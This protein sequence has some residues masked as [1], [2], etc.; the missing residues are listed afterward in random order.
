MKKVLDYAQFINEKSSPDKGKVLFVSFGKSEKNSISRVD[1]HKYLNTK[2]DCTFSSW[3]DLVFSENKILIGNKNVSDF[4]FVFMGVVGENGNYF[5]TLEKYCE[6]N[7]IPIFKY[8]C[9]TERNNKVY[10]NTTMSLSG[11]PQIPTIISK[12]SLLK[13][14][15]LV[16]ELNL[17][18]VTKI[19]NGSQGKGVEIQKTKMDLEKYLKKNKDETIIFQKFIENEGDY[20]IFII[21]QDIMYS[22]KRKSKDDKKEF[23][24]NYSL[25]GTAERLEIPVKAMNI[26]KKASK[27]MGF[28]V[29]GVD[30]IKEKGTDN[31]YVL[32]V[33]SAPQFDWEQKGKKS[34]ADYRDV[35]D[36]FVSIIKSKIS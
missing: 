8:G 17:P 18:M 9:S 24:N 12:C 35:L 13:S 31:W 4:D 1:Y 23:R 6:D 11:I 30:L 36:K 19:T 34:I 26:A 5:V 21:E 10:Q 3:E 16:K 32:E 2:L 22:I 7:K 20:R 33:N 25:G 15:D 14:E 28:D 27:A 29:S